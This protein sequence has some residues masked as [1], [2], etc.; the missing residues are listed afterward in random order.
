MPNDPFFEEFEK[1]R[2]LFEEAINHSNFQINTSGQK[3]SIKR[4]GNKT[5][6]DIQGDVSEEKI[7]Q[8]KRKYPD[9]E[10]NINGKTENPVEIIEETTDEESLSPEEL[11][12]KRFK[13]KNE[14]D[15]DDEE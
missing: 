4:T 6:I 15:N 2:K 10:I 9:A 8:L 14:E 13:E 7:N 1:L 5:R 12:L 3:I 11:A